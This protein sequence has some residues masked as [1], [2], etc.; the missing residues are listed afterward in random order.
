[1]SFVSLRIAI[2]ANCRKRA[3]RRKKSPQNLGSP[4]ENTT[5]S[6]RNFCNSSL[7]RSQPWTP[8]FNITASFSER[9]SVA[10]F[11]GKSERERF[12]KCFLTERNGGGR[13]T[14]S[15]PSGQQK[16]NQAFC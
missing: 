10:P 5:F 4:C 9:I 1:M 16:R 3:L 14:K 13:M 11:S 7:S 6:P 12:Q 8:F 2:F 15:F